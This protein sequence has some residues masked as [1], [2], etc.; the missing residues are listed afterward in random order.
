MAPLYNKKD[1]ECFPFPV[2]CV[3]SILSELTYWTFEM[4]VT[5]TFETHLQNFLCV[6]TLQMMK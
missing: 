4:K 3:S 6:S 5:V 2:P 1:M